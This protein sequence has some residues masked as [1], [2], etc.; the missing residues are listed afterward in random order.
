MIC[1]TSFLKMILALIS[2]LGAIAGTVA[3]SVS[4][5]SSSIA[6]IA[7]HTVAVGEV[8]TLL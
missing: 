4:T 5:T 2:L 7:T 3:Q 1:L 8:N 6:A